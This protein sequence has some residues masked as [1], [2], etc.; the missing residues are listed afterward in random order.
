MK[1]WHK[2]DTLINVVGLQGSL[3]KSIFMK[4]QHSATVYQSSLFVFSVIG[5]IICVPPKFP[6]V[7]Q[8]PPSSLVSRKRG[9]GAGAGVSMLRGGRG[10]V[11]WF[12]GLLVSCYLG[13]LVS[14]F[15]GFK[16]CW[17]LGVL[18][19][20]FQSFLVSKFLG[21]VVSKFLGFG[22]SKLHRFK[23]PIPC[24]W[25][26]LIQDHR[27]AI[28]YF[29]EDIDP[30]FKIF[31]KYKTSLH[32]LSAPVFSKIWK[33]WFLA[34]LRFPKNR[35]FENE[36]GFF[37][38]YLRSPGVSKNKIIGFG[39]NGHVQKSWNHENERCSVSPIMK[40]KSY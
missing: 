9:A 8:V 10:W 37:L 2:H 1:K 24:C 22:V 17:F 36:L 6:R 29:S 32:D 35:T 18:V 20:R 14:L 25:R 28:S 13:F 21:F 33:S 23:N 12:V 31:K 38:D 5:N 3:G 7:P 26:I 4:Q 40:T 19:S 16:V 15:L 11:F 27:I 39:A 30:I 34:I